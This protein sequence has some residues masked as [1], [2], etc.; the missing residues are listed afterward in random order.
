M[1]IMVLE[2]ERAGSRLVA[3][4]LFMLTFIFANGFFF[5]F[6][7]MLLFFFYVV[8]KIRDDKIV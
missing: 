6:V 8:E 4:V 5:L 7:V 3:V 2:R 1:H